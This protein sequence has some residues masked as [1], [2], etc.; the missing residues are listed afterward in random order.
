MVVQCLLN[1]LWL[2]KIN[3]CIAWQVA[4][5]LRAAG[6]TVVNKLVVD[7]FGLFGF[8][9]CH[10]ATVSTCPRC[11]DC[12]TGRHARPWA[13]P[14]RCEGS[15]PSGPPFSRSD[16]TA[17]WSFE[18]DAAVLAYGPRRLVRL[19]WHVLPSLSTF[20]FRAVYLLVLVDDHL[21]HVVGLDP[22]VRQHAV[23]CQDYL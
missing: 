20:G 19:V 17:V 23:G 8:S 7:Q 15:G 11:V 22:D 16:G 5:V 1:V 21:D 3:A 2:S 13:I 18:R 10:D 6:R 9:K 4:N 14:T 12:L